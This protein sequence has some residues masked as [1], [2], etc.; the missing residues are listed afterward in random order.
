MKL[1]VVPTPVGNREDITLR[2]LRL[3]K[4]VDLIVAEDTRN[5]GMLLKHLGVST[6]MRRYH[7]HNEHKVVEGLVDEMA[8]GLSVALVS[9]A[10]TPGISDPGF[11][12]V[13]ACL[14]RGVP[15]ECLPG[16]TAFVPA[17][18]ASGFPCDRFVF[19][20]FL[21]LKKGRK[22][23]LIELAESD[24]TVVL[25]EAPHRLL[26]LLDELTGICGPDRKACVAREISKVYEQFHRGTLAE[27]SA[28]FTDQPPRGELVVLLGARSAKEE[29]QTEA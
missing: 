21:P 20:G 14:K 13:R 28:Y 9:D 1:Y 5:T 17:L 12:L 15:V 29:N 22:T 27:L 10:G 3:L 25:Y 2:A 24:R 11:L 16:A 23:R 7:M 6:P 19:E 18:V 4:E 8:G 26:R